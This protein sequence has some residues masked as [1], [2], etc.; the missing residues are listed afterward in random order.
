MRPARLLRRALPGRPRDTPFRRIVAGLG[1]PRAARVLDIGAGGFVGET[2]TRH[3]TDLVDAPVVA[4]ERDEGRA[5]KLAERFGDAIEV[6]AADAFAYAPADRFD[7]AVVDLDTGLIPRVFDELLD[8]L[9]AGALAPGGHA[10]VAIVTDLA[11]AYAGPSALHVDGAEPM[12]AFMRERFGRLR[13]DAEVLARAYDEAGVWRVVD[14]VPKYADDPACYVGWAVLRL[15][16]G[17]SSEAPEPEAGAP[18]ASVP[19]AGAGAAR[20]DEPRDLPS[21]DA[22]VR[23]LARSG[24]RLALDMATL[25]DDCTPECAQ[26]VRRW[27]DWGRTAFNGTLPLEKTIG[28]W[29]EELEPPA[30]DDAELVVP[31]V[32]LALLRIPPDDAAYQQL[33]GAKSRN[34]L[35]KAQRAGI[36]TGPF[37]WNDRLDE[38]HAINTSKA[39]RSGGPMTES[40]LQPPAPIG[41]AAS[42]GCALHPTLY[43]GAER[44]GRLVGYSRL[45]AVGDLA[46]IDQIL[47]HA[48]AL[49]DGVMNALVHA[50][51]D[52]ARE[53]TTIVAINYLTL[54]SSTASLDR[55]K[56]SVGFEATAAVLRVARA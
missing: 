43:V 47:G 20:P 21:F 42:L 31:G 40:Y 54:R 49:P 35:R 10:V 7:L 48:D 53:R 19:E 46:V 23:R 34:M 27:S 50:L 6:V 14:L 2:T 9:A 12:A 18:D 1:L 41:G 4:L 26:H 16:G 51:V 38:I 11:L 36:A 29:R 24:P 52:A 3:L 33:I 45:V 30:G 39:V 8:R 32:A 44:E 37:H 55:F 25:R 56:R 28:P 22:E 13:L 15:E 5:A 17:G